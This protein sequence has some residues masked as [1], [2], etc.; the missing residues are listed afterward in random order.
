MD[1]PPGTVAVAVKVCIGSKA[2]SVWFPPLTGAEGA[3]FTMIFAVSL[4]EQLLPSV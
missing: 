3:V 4:L 2:H 1:C